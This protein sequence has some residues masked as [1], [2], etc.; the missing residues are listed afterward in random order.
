VSSE[1]KN[2]K[3]ICDAIAQHD[4]TCGEPVLAILM[5]PFEVERLGWDDVNGIPVQPE[6]RIQTGRFELTCNG[7]H[8]PPREANVE[9]EAPVDAVTRDRKLVPA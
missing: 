4:R 8:E 3:A 6:G 1:A 7:T 5:N 2:L 9:Y